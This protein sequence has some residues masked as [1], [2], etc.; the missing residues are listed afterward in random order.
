MTDVLA[1]LQPASWRLIAFPVSHREYGFRHEQARHKILFKDD[2]LIESLGREN[3][4]YSYTIP[5]REDIAKGP[6][7]NL[8]TVVY[9]DFLAACLDRS[10]DVL[11]DPI[12]GAVQA[13]CVSLRE[14]VD[15]DQRDGITVE[16]EFIFAP[17]ASSAVD[18][19]TVLD[20]LEGARNAA[21][22][23]DQDVQRIDWRQEVPP[24]PTLDPF[25]AI[26]SV[27][28]QIEVASGKL[29]AKMHDVAN[30]AEKAVATIDRVKNPNLAPTRVAARRLQAAALRLAEQGVGKERRHQIRS[31]FTQ[32][33]HTLSSVAKLL[34]NTPDEILGLNPSLARSP[35]IA[36]N[37]LVRYRVTVTS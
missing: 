10:R 3:P 22:L 4:T 21:G 15:V 33:E 16:A 9:P 24:E 1:Q 26:S 20:S 7:R 19:T 14:I 17:D 2:A 5:F 6:Y 12:H 28:N 37:T 34:D 30:R 18:L 31:T 13:K 29:S 32:H 35:R 27:G 23:F 8:F 36:T 25:D 11:E